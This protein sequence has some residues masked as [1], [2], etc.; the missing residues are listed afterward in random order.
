MFGYRCSLTQHVLTVGMQLLLKGSKRTQNALRYTFCCVAALAGVLPGSVSAAEFSGRVTATSEY[1]NR[2]QAVSNGNPAL[3]FSLDCALENGGFFG[4]WA[5]SIDIETPS[6]RRETELDYYIGY[7]HAVGARLDLTGT[8]I[9][10]TYPG[11]RGPIDYDYSE[12]LLTL[13]LD[14]RHS[15]EF[16]FAPEIY[17]LDAAG[18][19]WELRSER[20]LNNAWVV[21]AG[22]GLNDPTDY[23]WER[24]LSWDAGASARIGRLAVDVRW[25]DNEPTGLGIGG[26]SAGSQL[27]LSL[28]AVF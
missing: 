12:A 25:H 22:V 24:F 6:S 21:S 4:L 11:Q 28:S 3:Q 7:Q 13:T 10:Y 16:G 2:G 14:G 26:R 9:R 1:I 18:R 15:L 23:G 20:A 19:Y 17:G 8:L 5:S 27:V